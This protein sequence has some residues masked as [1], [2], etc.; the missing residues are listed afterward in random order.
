MNPPTESPAGPA[1]SRL[2]VFLAMA[3]IL[4]LLANVLLVGWDVLLRWLLRSPQS[5]VSDVAAVTYPVALACCFPA[6][7]EGGHMI[8]MR[9]LGERLGPRAALA[10]DV[11]GQA[12]L[13]ALLLV[14]SWKMAERAVADW[15]AG[16]TTSNIALPLAPSWAAVAALLVVSTVLQLRVTW[17]LLAGG[18][19][20]A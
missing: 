9:F 4:V 8:A 5:W 10:L 17:R 7:L 20:H 6:A 3:A 19:R 2:T 1:S 14:F 16:Y 12:S 13:G 18:P 11:L 15:G